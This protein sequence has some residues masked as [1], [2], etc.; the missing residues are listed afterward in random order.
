MSP[1][2]CEELPRAVDLLRGAS[3]TLRKWTCCK[4]TDT[5]PPILILGLAIVELPGRYAREPAHKTA[6]MAQEQQSWESGALLG[7]LPKTTRQEE[8]Q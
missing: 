1:G 7:E 6:R 5:R 8:R 3:V 4:C 2:P